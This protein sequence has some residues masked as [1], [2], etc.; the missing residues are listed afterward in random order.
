MIIALTNAYYY[1]NVPTQLQVFYGHIKISIG[2]LYSN[3]Q[4]YVYV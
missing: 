2:K 1:F 4:T 3:T